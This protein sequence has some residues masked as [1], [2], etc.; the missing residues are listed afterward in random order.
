MV[1]NNRKHKLK[2]KRALRVRSSLH[3]TPTKPRMCVVK[4]N[5][6]IQVQLIDDEAG[7]TIA[8]TSTQSKA[9]SKDKGI[10]R[11]KE[12]AKKLGVEIAKLAASK[13]VAEVVFDRGSHKYHGILATL[14]DAARENGLRF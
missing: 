14:A 7:V 9:F 2:V 4:S 1:V 5:K 13:E 6:H 8:A 12:S 10:G 11:N 3:G